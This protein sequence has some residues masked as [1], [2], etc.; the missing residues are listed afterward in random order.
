MEAA[1]AKPQTARELLNHGLSDFLSLSRE[2]FDASARVATGVEPRRSPADVVAALL[3]NDAQLTT[4]CEELEKM[5]SFE[6]KVRRFKAQMRQEDKVVEEL[7]AVLK[8]VEGQ[9]FDAIAAAKPVAEAH[10]TAKAQPVDLTDLMYVARNVSYTTRSRPK[11]QPGMPMKG[12]LRPYPLPA[13]MCCGARAYHPA[14]PSSPIVLLCRCTLPALNARRHSAHRNGLVWRVGWLMHECIMSAAPEIGGDGAAGGGGEGSAAPD[15]AAAAAVAPG[16]AAGAAA[17]GSA[18][19][20]ASAPAAA[21]AAAA[22]AASGQQP[23]KRIRGRGDG[24]EEEAAAKRPAAAQ[25]AAKVESA[26]AAPKAASAAPA[27]AAK[28]ESSEEED[29]DDDDDGLEWE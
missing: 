7:L 8:S 27:A 6:V 28:A 17:A 29:D 18:A 5:T 14:L 20:A 23:G 2:L 26:A 3:A 25:G 22:P 19:A 4:A 21:A 13:E 12:Y 24:A 10:Q 15:A 11:F 1:R 16:L 9:L